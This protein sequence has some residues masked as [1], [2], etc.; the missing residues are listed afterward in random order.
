[1]A[2]QKVGLGFPV[3]V[4]NNTTTAVYSVASNTKSYIRGILVHSQATVNSVVVDIHVVQNS[5]GSLGTVTA[6]NRVAKLSLQPRDTYFFELPFPIV[7]SATNDAIFVKNNAGS[8][9][10]ADDLTVLVLGDKEA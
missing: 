2:L 6:S 3:V 9:D 8:G 5:A 1:M 7:I 10:T 4:E